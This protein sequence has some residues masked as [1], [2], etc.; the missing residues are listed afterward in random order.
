MQRDGYREHSAQD[1]KGLYANLGWAAS[2]KVSTRFY[3]TYLDFNAELPR[4]LT[5]QQYQQDPFQAR[6][7]AILGDHRKRVE[8]WRLAFKTTIAEMAGGTLEF[9]LSYEDQSLYHPIVSTPF[10]SLLIDTE[11]KDSGAMLRYRRMAGAHDLV[12]GLQLRLL[13]RDWR[14]SA[15][16]R[17]PTR[18]VDV[19]DR[20]SASGLE[21]FAL[22]R[23]NFSPD[24]GRS[25]S[26][27]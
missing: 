8:A 11:H 14:Q 23:W 9:G 19:D 1:R 25:C 16:Y 17:W 5:P 3:V 21:L 10:F 20:D 22:D 18:R 13:D 12:F 26:G 2:D 24:S 15:E 4:E 6:A 7:D 27:R